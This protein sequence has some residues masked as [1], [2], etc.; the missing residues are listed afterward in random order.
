MTCTE[1]C[2]DNVKSSFKNE[3]YKKRNTLLTSMSI[4][5]YFM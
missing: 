5:L 2:G 3:V 1:H 4:F